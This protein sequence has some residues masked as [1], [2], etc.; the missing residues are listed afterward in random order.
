MLRN[1][2]WLAAQLLASTVLI[3]QTGPAGVGSSIDNGLWLRADD[4]LLAGGDRVA[5]WPDASGN[6]NDAYQSTLTQQPTFVASSALN[7][8]PGVRLDGLSNTG[9]GDR[10]I[11]DD[12]DILDGSDG[13]TYFAVLRV[14]EIDGNPRGIL[15]KRNDQRTSDES[16]S[17]TWYIHTNNRVFVDINTQ[18]NRDGAIEPLSKQTNYLLSFDFDGSR[19]SARRTR[20]INGSEVQLEF[21]E[22]STTI[23]N[24]PRPLVIGGLNDDYP[25]YLGADYAEVIHYN[26]ALS[27]LERLLVNNYLSGKYAIGLVSGDL[28]TRDDPGAGNYDFD[29]AG[30]GRMSVTDQLTDARG[31]GLL[32]ISTPTDLNDNEYLLWGHQGGSTDFTNLTDLPPTT[33][34]RIDRIWSVNEVS[35]TGTAVDVGGVTLSFDL[36]E[37]GAVEATEVRLLVDTDGDGTFADETPIDGATISGDELQFSEVTALANG[38]NFTLARAEAGLPVELLDIS[39]ASDGS[40]TTVRWSTLTEDGSDY[41]AVERRCGP[42]DRWRVVAEVPA[43][44]FSRSRRDYAVRDTICPE[45]VVYYRLRQVDLDGTAEY[46]VTVSAAPTHVTRPVTG[47]ALSF[48][49]NPAGDWI[50]LRDRSSVNLPL[51]IFN[52]LGKVVGASITEADRVFVGH[53]PTGAY[54]ISD[55]RSS[56]PLIK[57]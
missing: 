25:Q 35:G 16:Y 11:V 57:R 29:I 56:A 44:G 52:D 39:A 13:I 14:G 12:A 7:G 37:L 42:S 50:Y 36:T 22:A 2:L 45:E 1:A 43:A 20:I 33:G 24:S 4:L 28:Y 48:Y 40:W 54:W 32:R 8:R 31:S 26:R 18:N 3:A 51:S 53:L 38:R 23:F 41:F 17:Y 21:D 34:A 15:G 30:I 27:A 10:L 49:P 46:S 9:G 47:V 19:P 55:G 5:N 6:N